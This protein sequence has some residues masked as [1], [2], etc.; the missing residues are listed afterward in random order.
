[1]GI[2]LARAVAGG[3]RPQNKNGQGSGRGK[4]RC[5]K[6]NSRGLNSLSPGMVAQKF[7]F[8]AVAKR[9]GRA[10]RR[11]VPISGGSSHLTF[12]FFSDS[13]HTSLEFQPSF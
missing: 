10:L 8:E 5:E 1:M 11:R 6:R 13:F 2:F 12:G 4:T 3:T 7:T 9:R